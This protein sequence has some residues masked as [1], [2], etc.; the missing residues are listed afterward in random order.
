MQWALAPVHTHIYIHQT[1]TTLN[2]QLTRKM[3]E[4][5]PTGHR[6]KNWELK[7]LNL[8]V[9]KCSLDWCVYVIPKAKSLLFNL[10]AE[11]RK[12]PEG[13]KDLQ[14][15]NTRG[16]IIKTKVWLKVRDRVTDFVVSTSLWPATFLSVPDLT[17]SAEVSTH[18]QGLKDANTH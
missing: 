5:S 13:T 3:S 15:K 8:A 18:P 1:H 9:G 6:S 16:S 11:R 2:T 7:N 12:K 10:D 17:F 14:Y 4:K